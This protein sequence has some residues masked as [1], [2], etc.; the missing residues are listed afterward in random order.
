MMNCPFYCLNLRSP[1]IPVCRDVMIWLILPR[2][3]S[4]DDLLSIY[5]AFMQSWETCKNR[6]ASYYFAL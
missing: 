5:A 4:T 3:C 6:N 1:V 2:C